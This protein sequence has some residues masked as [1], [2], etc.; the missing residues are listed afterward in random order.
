M[1]NTTNTQTAITKVEDTS[2][3]SIV[4]E[5]DAAKINLFN[6]DTLEIMDMLISKGIQVDTVV[7]DVPFGAITESHSWDVIIPFN[8]MWERLNKIIKPGGTIVLFGNEPFS[9]A[10]RESNPEDYKYDWIWKKNTSGNHYNVKIMPQN[11]Y[12]NIMVFSKDKTIYN[13]QK[14]D[15]SEE[16]RLNKFKK[17]TWTSEKQIL[18]F[19]EYNNQYLNFNA[20]TNVGYPFA[21]LD[22]PSNQGVC[23]SSLRV[24]PTQK[25]IP[26][27]EYLV[28]THSNKGDIVLD[29]TMGSGSTG[30]A[31]KN[32]SRKFIGIELNEEYFNYAKD[33]INSAIEGV[34]L[35]N[36]NTKE[37]IWERIY[38]LNLED[39]TCENTIAT[40]IV[41]SFFKKRAIG[42]GLNL[43]QDNHGLPEKELYKEA[44]IKT[45]LSKRTLQRYKQFA[46]EKRFDTFTHKDYEK[47]A[48]KSINGILDMTNLSDEDFEKAAE[49]SKAVFKKPNTKSTEKDLVDDTV[50]MQ[51][52]ELEN[53]IVEEV[54]TPTE[55]ATI[56]DDNCKVVEA[57]VQD[58][59]QYSDVLTAEERK[60]LVPFNKDEAIE[61]L[62]TKLRNISDTPLTNLYE[63]VEENS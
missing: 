15:V 3:N 45:G 18:T 63:K 2:V 19:D 43:L 17:I 52:A 27:M 16:I 39:K 56:I 62:I 22:F 29:F 23:S 44:M 57:Q 36:V 20:N 6:G 14:R 10:L 54:I 42:T 24:H 53:D 28:K 8:E 26:L 58:Y 30:V 11:N 61:F 34:A 12:E 59:M 50:E 4:I 7:T 31:C 32:L 41:D 21:I 13:P 47:L 35:N 48:R 37:A 51:E 38:R 46:S 33:R 40:T 55:P 9:S 5:N 49:G 25:P 1:K 60:G